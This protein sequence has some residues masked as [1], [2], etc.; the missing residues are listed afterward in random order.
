MHSAD[1]AY[2]GALDAAQLCS[3]IPSAKIG[4]KH[5]T[6]FVRRK[7]AIGTT[8]GTKNRSARA[9]GVPRPVEDMILSIAY[10]SDAPWNDTVIKMPRVDELVIAARGELDKAKRK[11]MYSEVQMLIAKNG[12]T[13]IPAFGKRRCSRCTQDKIGIGPQDSAAA[14]KWTAATSSSAGGSTPNGANHRTKH[15]TGRARPAGFFR[16]QGRL[17]GR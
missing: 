6:S 11:E 13:L 16:S 1:T 14:G 15:Q 3:R 10:L 8:S 12:G 4:L 2:G 7:T 5:G 9:I 17:S